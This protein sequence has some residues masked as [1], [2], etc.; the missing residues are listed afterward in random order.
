MQARGCRIC[1]PFS[2]HGGDPPF[3]G[4]DDADV[5]ES[6]VGTGRPANIK[7]LHDDPGR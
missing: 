6:P 1:E 7:P 5:F 4:K 2:V 3:V